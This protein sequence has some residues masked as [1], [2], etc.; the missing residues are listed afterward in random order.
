MES[1]LVMGISLGDATGIGPEL[2]VKALHNDSIRNM[3]S[4]V[5][6]GDKRVFN[7]GQS[8]AGVTLYVHDI[9]NTSQISKERGSIH[10]IDLNNLSPEE[11]ELGRLS[12]ISGKATG[13]TLKYILELAKKGSIDGVIYGPLNKEALQRGGH[14]FEDELHF[15]ADYFGCNEGFGEINAMDNLWITRVTSHIP[16][17]AVSNELT[18]ERILDRI[19]FA[20]RNLKLAGYTKPKIYVASY[21]PHCGEGGLLGNEEIDA[22]IPAIE[23]AQKIGIDVHGPF[24]AD[25][26]F[27]RREN[28]KFD[29]IL[30]MYHDQAQIGIKLIGFNRGITINAGLPVILVT[31]AHGTAF[32]IAGKG[33]ANEGAT[34]AS[35]EMAVR[36]AKNKKRLSEMR[37]T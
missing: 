22:I 31:P 12:A 10:F 36:M 28:D 11:Y 9:E 3:A 20:D 30:S 5:I 29:C 34:K 7:Q 6:V 1:N 2:I 25:T 19:Q 17:K 14:H 15:Y 18:K 26:I 37:L 4:W 23:E 24:A 21:N 16:M 13:D 33:K 32:D 27:L 8:I 35:I